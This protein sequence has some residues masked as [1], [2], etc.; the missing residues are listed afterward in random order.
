[1]QGTLISGKQAIGCVMYYGMPEKDS[2]R[3]ESLN[4]PVLG[5]FASRDGWINQ[6]VVG[7]FEK[8]MVDLNKPL[9]VKWY[10]ADHAF[11]NPSSPRYDETASTDANKM[12]VQ[13]LKAD[14]LNN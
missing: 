7:E 5:I 9:T 11:A 8:K 4:A 2:K 14:Y 6:E 3:L 10:E 1:M 12:A 13:F